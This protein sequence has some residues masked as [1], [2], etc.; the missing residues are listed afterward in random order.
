MALRTRLRRLERGF[1]DP[2]CP[3][4]RD[5]RGLTALVRSPRLADGTTA[6]K[7]DR[8]APCARCGEVAE[9]V[10]E[11]VEVVVEAC[12]DASRRA[13]DGRPGRAGA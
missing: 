12:E 5:R 7:G 9:R 1:P 4:C 11:V 3:A 13:A 10:T 8:P 6:P 2:G